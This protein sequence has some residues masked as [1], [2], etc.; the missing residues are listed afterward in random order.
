MPSVYGMLADYDS[1]ILGCIAFVFL[2]EIA[3]LLLLVLVTGKQLN[4]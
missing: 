3:K 2:S 1:Q 4:C